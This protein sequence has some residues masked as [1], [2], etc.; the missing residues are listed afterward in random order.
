MAY[1]D[2][3]PRVKG[4]REHC[5]SV[6]LPVEGPTLNPNTPASERRAIGPSTSDALASMTGMDV[7]S[8]PFTILVYSPQPAA[9]VE[10][11]ALRLAHAIAADAKATS[12]PHRFL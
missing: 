9:D 1:F 8:A 11:A 3:Y 2:A 4:R 7:K 10:K 5:A 6:D 12:R